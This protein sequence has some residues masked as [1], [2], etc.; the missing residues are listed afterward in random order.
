MPLKSSNLALDKSTLR[1]I[2]AR[3]KLND[4]NVFA[5][6]GRANKRSNPWTTEAKSPT[7]ALKYRVNFQAASRPAVGDYRQAHAARTGVEIPRTL[8]PRFG[9]ASGVID[10]FDR[11]GDQEFAGGAGL[12]ECVAG[13]EG[14]PRLG[15]PSRLSAA[16]HDRSEHPGHPSAVRRQ[17]GCATTIAIFAT[18]SGI[19]SI[20]RAWC[21]S[22]WSRKMTRPLETTLSRPLLGLC[23]R[24]LGAFCCVSLRLQESGMVGG[25]L[26]GVGNGK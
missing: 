2:P 3:K 21:P 13:A 25:R 19:D 20:A 16:R 23:L 9:P 18:A 4:V 5:V 8:A 15:R 11:A 6:Q 14:N 12:E 24:G 22:G 26:V 7:S 17:G 10:H 1:R